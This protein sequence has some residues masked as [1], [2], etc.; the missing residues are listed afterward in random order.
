MTM[1]GH[2]EA[3]RKKHADLEDEIQKEN[4]QAFPNETLIHDLKIK[5]LQIKDEIFQITG[6]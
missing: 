2:L 3:L 6:A 5:K 1:A 4:N